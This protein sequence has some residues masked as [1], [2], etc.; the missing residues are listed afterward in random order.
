[1][2]KQI[3]VLTATL[4]I[5]SNAECKFHDCGG[6]KEN[7]IKVEA[8][9]NCLGKLPDYWGDK[10]ATVEDCDDVDLFYWQKPNGGYLSIRKK[11]SMVKSIR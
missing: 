11:P 2:F 3:S 1:M 5:T 9:E 10:I 8:D 7:V 4:L 6:L